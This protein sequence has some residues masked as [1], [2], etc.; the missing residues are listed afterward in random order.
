[1]IIEWNTHIFSPTLIL[2]ASFG[3]PLEGEVS[4]SKVVGL[5]KELAGMAVRKRDPYC[6]R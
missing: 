4:E 3:C 6:R 5:A 2:T 1:M